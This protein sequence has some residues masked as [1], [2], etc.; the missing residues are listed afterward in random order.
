MN[1]PSEKSTSATLLPGKAVIPPFRPWNTCSRISN[2]DRKALK[3]DF[4][5]H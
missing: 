4:D 3:A 5:E 2:G 1:K